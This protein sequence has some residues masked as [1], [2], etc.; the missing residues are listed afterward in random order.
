[1]PFPT[2]Q[3]VSSGYF[4]VDAAQAVDLQEEPPP[5]STIARTDLGLPLKR[6]KVEFEQYLN[7]PPMLLI[8]DVGEDE[9]GCHGD[10]LFDEPVAAVLEASALPQRGFSVLEDPVLSV[11]ERVPETVDLNERAVKSCQNWPSYSGNGEN[12]LNLVENGENSSSILNGNGE[13]SLN[14]VKNGENLLPNLAKNQEKESAAESF[15][16][17]KARLREVGVVVYFSICFLLI[18]TMY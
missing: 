14:S 5:E 16:L 17:K 11:G 10:V 9:Q 8:Y 6:R 2:T 18:I 12:S 4:D 13:N 15:R 3:S 1:L 7:A